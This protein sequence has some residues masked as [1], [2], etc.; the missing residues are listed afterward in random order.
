M[1]LYTDASLKGWGAMLLPDDGRFWVVGGSWSV[2]H[3]SGDISA[4]EAAAIS[5]AI[6]ILLPTLRVFAKGTL[7]IV[8][9]NTAVQA[10]VGRGLARSFAVNAA[11]FPAL[12]TLY[13]IGLALTI[14]YIA[15][16]KNPV[17]SVSRGLPVDMAKLGVEVESLRKGGRCRFSPITDRNEN[18][19][20]VA[21]MC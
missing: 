14:R 8:V 4:L 18:R 13:D 10:A 3:N 12:R 6:D 5:R 15:T 2:V 11:L 20:V 17:D 21:A 9:D 19:P 1:W 7:N 16:E